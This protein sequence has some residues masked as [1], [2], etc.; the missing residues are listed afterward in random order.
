MACPSGCINGGGQ[1]K[2]KTIQEL[3]AEENLQTNQEL[4]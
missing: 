4:V 1:V 2:L 3:K